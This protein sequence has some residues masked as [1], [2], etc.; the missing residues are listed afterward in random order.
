MT[1]A[2]IAQQYTRVLKTRLGQW[3]QAMVVKEPQ[4]ESPQIIWKGV[5]RMLPVRA[6]PENVETA[7]LTALRDRRFFRNCVRCAE[8][9]P[10]SLI[11]SEGICLECKGILFRPAVAA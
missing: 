5:G 9:R 8:L 7:R 10:P 2:E 6:L 4:S 3:V 11:L 1:E